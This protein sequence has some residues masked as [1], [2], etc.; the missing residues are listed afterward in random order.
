MAGVAKPRSIRRFNSLGWIRSMYTS[1]RRR[2]K[3]WWKDCV[4][5]PA[6][7][8]HSPLRTYNVHVLSG[9]V[10]CSRAYW[11]NTVIPMSFRENVLRYQRYHTRTHR[12]TSTTEDKVSRRVQLSRLC[13][14]R[15]TAGVWMR[16]HR[17]LIRPILNTS[18]FGAK[19]LRLSRQIIFRGVSLCNVL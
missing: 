17:S 16:F 19:A 3:S 9:L 11:M 2:W 4:V 14:R 10:E 6:M 13:Q 8:Q 18:A 15:N 1:R 12:R 7:G 5:W